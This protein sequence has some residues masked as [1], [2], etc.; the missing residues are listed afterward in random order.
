MQAARGAV[1]DQQLG[2]V[3]RVVADQQD[4]VAE[5]GDGV[6]RER[7]PV[8]LIRHHGDRA[9]G[10]VDDVELIRVAG[11]EEHAVAGRGQAVGCVRRVGHRLGPRRGAV[12]APQAERA[13]RRSRGDEVGE[14]S[15]RDQR[16][17]DVVG[18]HLADQLG[19]GH[20]AVHA[21]QPEGVRDA[22]VAI[23]DGQRRARVQGDEGV[24][25]E[26]AEAVG[27]LRRAVARQRRRLRR[28]QDAV[29]EAGREDRLKERSATGIPEIPQLLAVEVDDQEVFGVRA[30]TR[31]EEQPVSRHQLEARGDVL[32]IELE[33]A[34]EVAGEGDDA[35]GPRPSAVGAPQTDRLAVVGEEVDVVATADQ[36]AGQRVGVAVRGG[37]VEQQT[38]PVG[39]AVADPGLDAVHAV[40][41]RED[42]TARRAGV[43]SD[44]KR[45][46]AEAG[47]LDGA[48]RRAVAEPEAGGERGVLE[49]HSRPRRGGPQIGERR[50]APVAQR[51]ERPGAGGRAVAEP[52]L[53]VVEPHHA[54]AEGVQVADRAGP[55]ARRTLQ[56]LARGAFVAR[57]EPTVLVEEQRRADRHDLDE[58][59]DRRHP[60]RPGGGAVGRPQL[61][62]EARVVQREGDPVGGGD[63]PARAAVDLGEASGAG[64]GPV[65]APH[66]DGA[67]RPLAEQQ[68]VGAEDREAPVERQVERQR[69]RPGH[70]AVAHQVAAV[71]PPDQHPA[72]EDA[73]HPDRPAVLGGRQ[74][75]GPR[76]QA[77]GDPQPIP[78]RG[79]RDPLV[80]L[81][82]HPA[83]AV[84]QQHRSVAAAQRAPRSGQGQRPRAGGRPVADP[85]D[86][87]AGL[88]RAQED[89][90]A[91]TGGGRHRSTL[92][93]AAQAGTHVAEPEGAAHR[94]VG[95]PRLPPVLVVRG[96]EHH[97]AVVERGQRL[98]A[99]VR[100]GSEVVVDVAQ[101]GRLGGLG[102]RG[103]RQ[104]GGETEDDGGSRREHQAPPGHENQSKSAS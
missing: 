9:G 93:G 55:A 14:P 60:R 32:L 22:I 62:H 37:Q 69:P 2:T 23:P 87:L 43:R 66:L 79:R 104:V 40:V 46:G 72:A 84:R 45:L 64:I 34:A 82:E 75:A 88:A 16:A 52:E 50:E 57:P 29:A 3:V 77:V 42:Q 24:E 7:L 103:E 44:R 97:P 76:R 11:E 59:A 13:V 25:L 92:E 12:A 86:R 36:P 47:Q 18:V 89:Q 49:D 19:P 70:R 81:D 99:A 56:R 102:A 54:V 30:A 78:R 98:E 85:Q 83:V 90:G 53:V 67:A 20:G 35:A 101:Q 74:R 1:G 58:V 4:A 26:V 15:R 96:G 61:V 21:P 17:A 31:Q 33:A 100:I 41:G 71:A 38:R 68:S 10:A 63:E 73:Q 94:P 80:H 39:R 27:S 95:H 28:D 5:R 48:A 65:A 8:E 6:D 51:A 91:G